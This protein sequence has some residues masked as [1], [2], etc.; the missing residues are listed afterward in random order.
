MLQQNLQQIK[1]LLK[2][3]HK[4][5]GV[6]EWLNS[7]TLSYFFIIS[8][9]FDEDLILSCLIFDTNFMLTN[10]FT[11]KEYKKLSLFKNLVF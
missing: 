11:K 10:I 3:Y 5:G 9:N 6:S 8:Y 2:Y 4:R 7:D 1:M